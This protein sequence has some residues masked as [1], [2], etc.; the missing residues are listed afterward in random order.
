[1]TRGVVIGKFL[2][3]HKG[4]KYLIETALERCDELTVIVCDSEGDPIPLRTRMDWI[5]EEFPLGIRLYSI[6]P[7]SLGLDENDSEGWARETIKFLGFV[8]DVA[9]TSEEY[10]PRWSKFMGCEHFMVDIDRQRYPVSGTKVRENPY[11]YKDL[12]PPQVWAYY[13]PRLL[14]VG[15]ESTGKTTLAHDLADWLNGTTVEEFGR[16]YTEAMPDPKKYIWTSR[17]FDDIAAVQNRFEDSAA[18][19]AELLVVDTNVFTTALFH[20]AYLGRQSRHLEEAGLKR[21]Y[22]LTILTDLNSPFE[23][24]LIGMRDEGKREWFHRR[25]LKAYPDA[26]VV[27]GSQGERV[28][29]VIDKLKRD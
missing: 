23:Q 16:Y 24:D 13:C 5:M 29:Q 1:M 22:N 3:F 20:E 21:S 15:A 11:I 18:R 25:Y 14:I 9:I 28:Q 8:P 17:D 27:S 10:G 26:L 6:K 12:L 7:D 19:W 2:P 4:H